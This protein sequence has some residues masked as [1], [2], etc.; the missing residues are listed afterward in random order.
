MLA[1]PDAR[2]GT[3]DRR[4]QSSTLLERLVE[5]RAT[6]QMQEVEGLVD[7][8]RDRH[9]GPAVTLDPLLQQGEIRLASV[10]ECDDLAVDDRPA[11]R[12]PRRRREER[13]EVPGR[14]LLATR[15]E[16]DGP[17]IDDGLDAE[18]VPLD[19]ELPV[20]VVERRADE[21]REHRRDEAWCCHSGRVARR[22][23][24]HLR[25]DR[26]SRDDDP[27]SATVGESRR[28]ISRQRRT[29]RWQRR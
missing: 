5:Q 23:V 16:P 27:M 14:V 1:H 13:P 11:R 20:G 25:R 26:S 17:A 22:R 12:D 4:E 18:A 24:W 19:I 9:A 7:E 6:I 8:R 2:I 15:P 10:V 21:R 28:T 3:K 29:P